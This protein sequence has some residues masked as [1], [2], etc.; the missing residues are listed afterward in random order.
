MVRKAEAVPWTV[1]AAS[2]TCVPAY[3][4]AKE[5][6][7]VATER[8]DGIERESDWDVLESNNDFEQVE[9]IGAGDVDVIEGAAGYTNSAS[10][11]EIV[12][13]PSIY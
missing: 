12:S 4:S 3:R 7:A 11:S 13:V 1:Y 5:R 9:Q 6:K 8:D 10:C 2:S